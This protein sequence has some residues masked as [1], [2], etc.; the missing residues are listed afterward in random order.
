MVFGDK[1][2]LNLKGILMRILA[3]KQDVLWSG[4]TS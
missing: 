4:H 2:S 3:G 1:E